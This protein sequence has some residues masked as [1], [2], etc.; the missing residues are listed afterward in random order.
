MILTW[1]PDALWCRQGVTEDALVPQ[2]SEAMDHL[3]SPVQNHTLDLVLAVVRA[4]IARLK[5]I[6]KDGVYNNPNL[7]EFWCLPERQLPCWFLPV[8]RGVVFLPWQTWSC[9][10]RRRS[11]CF[12]W[13]PRH[14]ALTTAAG[15]IHCGCMSLPCSTHSD[16]HIYKETVQYF[17]FFALTFRPHNIFKYIDEK[18]WVESYCTLNNRKLTTVTELDTRWWFIAV[19]TCSC[20]S[21]S[22]VHCVIAAIE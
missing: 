15:S 11:L 18:Y 8:S 13:P 22:Y 2:A 7:L 21:C 10:C 9:M 17:D 14:S 6:W 1:L 5:K 19:L 4:P 3:S 16:L 20:T 12:W